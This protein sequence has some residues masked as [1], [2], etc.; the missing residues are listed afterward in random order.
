MEEKIELDEQDI[1]DMMVDF[2]RERHQFW[3]ATISKPTLI[4]Y[5]NENV[6]VLDG[7]ESIVDDAAQGVLDALTEG[8]Y[9]K[10]TEVEGSYEIYKY[11]DEEANVE[12][13]YEEQEELEELGK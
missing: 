12:V 13:E 3:S 2:I 10:V 1:V 6:D 8:G 7:A 5:I 9:L 11:L 4:N